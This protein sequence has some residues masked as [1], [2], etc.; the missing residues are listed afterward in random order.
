MTREDIRRLQSEASARKSAKKMNSY[1]NDDNWDDNGM[2]YKLQIINSFKF[3]ILSFVLKRRISL[4]AL[5]A[6][7]V[8]INLKFS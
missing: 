2:R 4:R 7:K 1:E 3:L 8:S 5:S 6:R